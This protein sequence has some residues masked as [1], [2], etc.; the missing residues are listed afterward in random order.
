[1]VGDCCVPIMGSPFFVV[2][3]EGRLDIVN[4]D[5]SVCVCIFGGSG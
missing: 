5:R 3:C 2:R 1:M 4:Q